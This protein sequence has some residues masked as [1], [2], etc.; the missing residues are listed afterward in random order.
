MFLFR[1]G[2]LVHLSLEIFVPIRGGSRIFFRRGG[3]VSCSTSTPINHIFFFLQNT[4]CIRKPQ[5][6]SGR[7]GANPL[8]PSPRSAPANYNGLPV[9]KLPCYLTT[10]VYFTFYSL[11]TYLVVISCLGS[12]VFT[13]LFLF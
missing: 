2:T 6:I 7:G 11:P 4:S 12:V 13:F 8:H 10:V 3:L 1:L 5:L 9:L